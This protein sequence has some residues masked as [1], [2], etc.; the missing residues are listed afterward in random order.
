MDVFQRAKERAWSLYKGGMPFT[1]A[2]YRAA[3]EFDK[4]GASFREILSFL[5]KEGTEHRRMKATR[6]R[7]VSKPVSKPKPRKPRQVQGEFSFE[8]KLNRALGLE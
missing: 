6:R 1:K 2:T 8:E 5:R 4:R 3:Q 7:A